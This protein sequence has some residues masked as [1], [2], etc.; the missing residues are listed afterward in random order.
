MEGYKIFHYR[1]YNNLEKFFCGSDW[2]ITGN[3]LNTGKTLNEIYIIA[4][5]LSVK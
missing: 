1:L 3:W 5:I 4:F 2:L